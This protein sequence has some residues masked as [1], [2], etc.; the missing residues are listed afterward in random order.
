MLAGIMKWIV[1]ICH[2]FQLYLLEPKYFK[3]QEHESF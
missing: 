3:Q 1:L 2:I